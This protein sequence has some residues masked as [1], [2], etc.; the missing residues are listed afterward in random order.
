MRIING[1]IITP[2]AVLVD[3]TL[4]IQDQKIT[5]INPAIFVSPDETTL[6]AGGMWVA[7]G[8]ID[9]HVHGGAGFDTMDATSHAL[10]GMA[11]FFAR[12][13]V[14]SYFPTTMSA[15]AAAIKNAIENVAST[16][17]PTDGA[18]H[19]GV[20]VEGPYLSHDYP[21]AQAVD[22]LRQADPV[23]YQFWL[24]SG[25]VKL[26]T[27]APELAGATPLI[28]AGTRQGIEF[29]IGHSGAS[30]EEVLDAAHQ[31][32]RQATHTFNGM[33][34]LHHRN[35][36]TLG[37]VLTDDRLYAQLIGDGIHVHPAMVKLLVRA[38]GVQRT[39]LIT[40]SMRAAGL[41]DGDYDLGEQPVTVSDGVARIANGSLAGSTS[42]LDAVLRNVIEFTGLSLVE[43]LPMATSVPAAAMHLNGRKGEISI[44]ADA[45]IIF[46]N[47]AHEV[48]LTMVGG[49][50]VYEA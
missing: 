20:H 5:A 43:A 16:T 11:R 9:V 35:P 24:E 50:V 34:G 40:D 18:R 21:G 17:Q 46:L 44:G 19:L 42:T 27:L 30:Y 28:N 49:K 2:D 31:G 13:G 25:V 47:E 6:D 41:P 3:S 33:L 37:G 22:V 26:I 15:P 10:H 1:K 39:I 32:V 36:G 7:P 23:E 8:L 38:K 14:T 29:A 48:C 45:D 12:H 4:V